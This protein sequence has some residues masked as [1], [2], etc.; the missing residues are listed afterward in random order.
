MN[1]QLFNK[2]LAWINQPSSYRIEENVIEIEAGTH[3]DLFSDPT[4]DPVFK[5]S[6]LL[7]FQADE[8]FQFSARLSADLKSKFDAAALVIYANGNDIYKAIT[9]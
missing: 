9:G 4:G 3:T 2:P 1:I 5:N 6:P 8:Y 7:L